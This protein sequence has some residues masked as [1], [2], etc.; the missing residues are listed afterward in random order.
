MDALILI[1]EMVS[2]AEHFDAILEGLL[3]EY[4]GFVVSV[5]TRTDP[6]T[7]AEI[8]AILLSFEDK[9]EKHKKT[10][11]SS[12]ASATANVAQMSSSNNQNQNI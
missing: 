12:G 9:I 1:G 11:E 5:S 10:V 6:Y 3:D 4:D 7:V 8:E 2:I